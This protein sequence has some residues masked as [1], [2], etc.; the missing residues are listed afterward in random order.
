MIGTPSGTP[1]DTSTAT[2]RTQGAMFNGRL[3]PTASPDGVPHTAPFGVRV[4]DAFALKGT[5][6]YLTPNPE[7]T[8][9]SNAPRCVYPSRCKFF[10]I[11]CQFVQ[12]PRG[13]NR[14]W[15]ICDSTSC[16]HRCTR[17]LSQTPKTRAAE[18]DNSSIHREYV[19]WSYSARTS[20]LHWTS[21]TLLLEYHNLRSKSTCRSG[22]NVT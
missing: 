6:A 13:N 12:E 16:F 5:P 2:S 19:S 18:R 1:A 15:G 10:S 14:R 7:M 21:Q 9:E 22:F 17:P 11:P 20:K 4:D 8:Q 3:G